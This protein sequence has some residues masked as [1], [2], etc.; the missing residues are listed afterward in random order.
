MRCFFI[1]LAC[2]LAHVHSYAQPDTI[3]YDQDIFIFIKEYPQ[4]TVYVGNP[5]YLFPNGGKDTLCFKMGF[6]V[7]SCWG[8]SGPITVLQYIAT[9]A[10]LHGIALSGYFYTKSMDTIRSVYC[11]YAKRGGQMVLLDTVDFDNHYDVKILEMDLHAR[12]GE[13]TATKLY[14]YLYEF[15]FDTPLPTI[16]GEE[17]FV[18]I[19]FYKWLNTPNPGRAQDIWVMPYVKNEQPY[20]YENRYFGTAGWQLATMMSSIGHW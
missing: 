14:S 13:D 11:A 8:S 3:H 19:Y 20:W 12:T 2:A 17:I 1:F 16:Q 6:P 10:P 4:D 5:R 18:G 15:Y 7:T 9:G